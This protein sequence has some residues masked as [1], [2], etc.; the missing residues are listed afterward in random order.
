MYESSSVFRRLKHNTGRNG[1][2]VMINA[3]IIS[4][5]VDVY[6]STAVSGLYI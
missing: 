1:E 3:I 2:Y 6:K 4:V 5:I